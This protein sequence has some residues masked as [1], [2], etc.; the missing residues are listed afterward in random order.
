MNKNDLYLDFYKYV[1]AI[2]YSIHSNNFINIFLYNTS[3]NDIS[4]NKKIY[5][6]LTICIGGS[7]YIA[8]SNIFKK[9][10]LIDNINIDT[11][12]Y[13]FSFSIHKYINNNEIK[14]IINEIKIIINYELKNYKFKNFDSKIFNCEHIIRNDRIHIKLN[15]KLN[16]YNF[17]IL[18]LSFWLNGKVSDNFTI[19]DFKCNELI[20]YE[21]NN[22]YYYLLPLDLLIE[23]SFY[24]ISDFFERR[25]FEK[26]IKYINRITFIKNINKQYM[27]LE[28]KPPIL[29]KILD[30]YRTKIKR[31]Y[32]II[33]DYP[34]ILAKDLVTIK[35]N[36]VIKCIYKNMRENNHNKIKKIINEY[37]EKCKN[38]ENYDPKLSEITETE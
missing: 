15:C 22:V 10:G 37:K 9:F 17:H 36:G 27:K 29:Y 7:A 3:F 6:P 24:A 13:D 31:K 11:M 12:D 2:I 28:N 14:K 1:N 35:N 16:N 20:L 33:N 32:Q 19:N 4:I 5:L 34:F 18:E 26:C 8:Y 23:T 25:F 21:N 30:N 38:E